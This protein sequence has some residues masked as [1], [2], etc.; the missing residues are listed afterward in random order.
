MRFSLAALTRRIRNPRRKAIALREIAPTTVLATSLYRATYAHIVAAVGARIDRIM[1]AYSRALSAL[2]HDSPADV[3]AE[4]DGL[5][6][7]LDRLVLILTPRM[8]DWALRV[9]SWQRGKW[10][11]AALSATG[12]DLQTMLGPEDV[13]QSIEATIAWNTSLIKDVSAQAQLR[14]SAAVFAGLNERRAAVDVAKDIRE[15]VAMSRTRSVNIAADQLSKLSSSLDEERMNQ[16]GIE[17]FIYRHSGKM[18][19]R[20][21]HRARNGRTYELATGKEVGGGDV[22]A[23]GDGPGQPPF[24]GCRRQA[25]VTFD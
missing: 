15:A 5:K 22:I 2:I 3:T 18:H 4:L 8:R 7:E 12:V 19:P 21:W 14:I 17:E 6:Q 9:E 20:P 23:P 24:C 13:R 16:A 25:V 11:G 10:A 1:A